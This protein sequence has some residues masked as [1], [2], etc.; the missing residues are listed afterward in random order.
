MPPEL[1][2]NCGGELLERGE[3]L[4]IEPCGLGR[5]RHAPARDGLPA[6]RQRHRRRIEHRSRRAC[7]GRS[8]R[9]GRF[10]GRDALAPADGRRAIPCRL[11]GLRM[12]DRP[13]PA[14]A[15]RGAAPAPSRWGRPPAGRSSPTL[16]VGIAMAYLSPRDRFK[17]GDIVEVDVRG[18]TGRRRGR[19]AAVRRIEPRGSSPLRQVPEEQ[20][21]GQAG[22]SRSPRGARLSFSEW[23][24]RLPGP[25]RR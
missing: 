16:R 23:A 9:Q 5:A 11:W 22:P 17:P 15:L 10:L 18:R 21:L 1:A 14:A 8:P 3:P 25:R 20:R 19:Q 13:D 4:G 7:R 6:P 12:K 24:L 2:R